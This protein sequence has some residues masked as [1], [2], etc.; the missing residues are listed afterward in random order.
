MYFVLRGVQFVSASFFFGAI[1]LIKQ[2]IIFVLWPK[3]FTPDSTVVVHFIGPYCTA[4]LYMIYAAYQSTHA[5]VGSQWL[6]LRKTLLCICIMLILMWD[7]RGYWL[8][9]EIVCFFCIWYMWNFKS[10]FHLFTCNVFFSIMLVWFPLHHFFLHFGLGVEKEGRCNIPRYFSHQSWF[11]SNCILFWYICTI[12]LDKRDI[13]RATYLLRKLTKKP[14]SVTQ[15]WWT[16]HCYRYVMLLVI[17][18]NTAGKRHSFV[19]F[20]MFVGAD[21]HILNY[22]RQFKNRRT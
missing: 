12:N 11:R 20:F 16:I 14:I 4:A 2:W 9:N 22:V 15:L 3:H 5:L 21:V 7:V 17:L 6:Q 1:Y 18:A 13:C 10:P 19:S 8:N